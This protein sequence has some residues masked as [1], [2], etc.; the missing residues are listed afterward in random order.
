MNTEKAIE[1][2]KNE[3]NGDNY[4]AIDEIIELLRE[5]EMYGQVCMSPKEFYRRVKRIEIYEEL[6]EFIRETYNIYDPDI[7]WAY[8]IGYIDA[9][10]DYT[11]SF[12]YDELNNLTTLNDQLKVI[13]KIYT[14]RV[15]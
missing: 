2:L 1:F 6:K 11:H 8:N 15:R 12:T 10:T 14:R 5:G 4:K 9:L 13:Q 3:I 7:A